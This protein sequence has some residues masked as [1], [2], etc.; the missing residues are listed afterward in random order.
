[1][2]PLERVSRVELTK[3]AEMRQRLWQDL[4]GLVR[5]GEGA[6]GQKCSAQDP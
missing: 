6:G 2:A 5:T 3:P 1:M 4:G